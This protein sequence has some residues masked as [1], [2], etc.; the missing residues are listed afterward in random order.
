MIVFYLIVELAMTGQYA[1]VP[2]TITT[3]DGVILPIARGLGCQKETEEES[4]EREQSR[5]AGV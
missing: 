5:K 2:M 4:S 3:K 1:G